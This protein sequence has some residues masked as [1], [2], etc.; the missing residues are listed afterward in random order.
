MNTNLLI[1]TLLC[2]VVATPMASAGGFSD[3]VDP[4]IDAVYTPP[5]NTPA[6]QAYC[7]AR[8]ITT[9]VGDWLFTCLPGSYFDL[10]DC[11][12]GPWVYIL[13]S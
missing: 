2:L 1:G 7:G 9:H 8:S 10:A 11:D 12:D 5:C 3:T 4:I 6:Q 13:P